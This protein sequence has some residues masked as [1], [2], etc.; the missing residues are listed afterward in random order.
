LEAIAS[1]LVVPLIGL[2]ALDTSLPYSL[3]VDKPPIREDGHDLDRSSTPIPRASRTTAS[4]SLRSTRC[5]SERTDSDARERGDGM[6][7]SPDV[8]S[9]PTGDYIALRLAGSAS[10]LCLHIVG[11]TQRIGLSAIVMT[12]SDAAPPISRLWHRASCCAAVLQGMRREPHHRELR[13][14]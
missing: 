10:A 8:E 7:R 3:S 4:D 9:W 6:G 5:R 14:R 13:R 12:K 2:I 11:G 1:H